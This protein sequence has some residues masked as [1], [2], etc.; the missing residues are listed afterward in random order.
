MEF[1]FNV[2]DGAVAFMNRIYMEKPA[3]GRD[4]NNS[5]EFQSLSIILKW[6]VIM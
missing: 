2:V 3:F 6:R 5:G 4:S 1:V